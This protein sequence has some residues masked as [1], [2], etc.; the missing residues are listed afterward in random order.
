MYGHLQPITNTIQVSKPDMGVTTEDVGMNSYVKC[1]CGPL[2]MDEKKLDD[3]PELVILSN[4]Q[5]YAGQRTKKNHLFWKCLLSDEM[6]SP[7]KFQSVYREY[8]P[9]KLWMEF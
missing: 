8:F 2:H 7:H 4:S 9:N 5:F 6:V 3:Q 1:T